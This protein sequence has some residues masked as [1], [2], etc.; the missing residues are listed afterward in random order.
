MAFVASETVGWGDRLLVCATNQKQCL[1]KCK[2]CLSLSTPPPSSG[3]EWSAHTL[4][5]TSDP[6][7][8]WGSLASARTVTLQID[9]TAAASLRQ[10]CR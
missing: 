2:L 5:G 1:Y 4:L 7:E 8:A 3:K 9:G 10:L 6:G